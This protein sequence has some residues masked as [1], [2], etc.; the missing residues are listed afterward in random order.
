MFRDLREGH[1]LR[2][3]ELGVIFPIIWTQWP[4]ERLESVGLGLTLV[5]V[6]LP[7]GGGP[8]LGSLF[9]RSDNDR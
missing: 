7:Y 2:H 5:T 6:S 9:L 4:T 1:D 3:I 8:V